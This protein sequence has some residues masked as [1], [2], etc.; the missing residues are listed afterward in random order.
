M[1]PDLAAIVT[2]V[3]VVLMVFIFVV[4]LIFAARGA[5]VI[6]RKEHENDGRGPDDST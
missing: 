4:V 1:E 6:R 2:S 5:S 3:K